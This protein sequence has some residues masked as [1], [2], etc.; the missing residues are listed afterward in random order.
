MSSTRHEKQIVVY[1]NHMNKEKFNEELL[2]GPQNEERPVEN[3]EGIA[4]DGQP[5][6]MA[7]IPE[8][9]L[10]LDPSEVQDAKNA[11]EDLDPKVKELCSRV[12]LDECRKIIEEHAHAA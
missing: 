9:T 3:M 10:S 2:V 8:D 7:L 11:L 4:G 5:L 1:L 6:W 12:P